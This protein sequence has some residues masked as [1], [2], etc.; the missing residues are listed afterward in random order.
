MSAYKKTGSY[1]LLAFILLL[2][3]IYFYHETIFY[4]P[5][6]IHAWT[7]S[8][9]LSIA[10]QFLENG[11]NLFKP[12]THNLATVEGVTGVDLPLNEFLV[13]IS[14]KIFNTEAPFIF[15]LYTL[16]LSVAGF[17]YLFRLSKLLNQHNV[18]CSIGVVVFVFTCPVITYY[19]AGLIPS[20]GSFAIMLMAYYYYFSFLKQSQ[21]KH[22][23]IS[24]VMLTLAALIRSP[25]NIYLFAVLLHQLLQA[26]QNRKIE[27]RQLFS[28]V[29]A[30]TILITYTY[31]K[32]WLNQTYGSQFLTALMPAQN[33]SDFFQTLNIVW[34]TW[35]FQLFTIYHYILLGLAII[36]I[37]FSFLKKTSIPALVKH[38]LI[39]SFILITGFVVYFILMSKQFLHHEYYFID[40]FYAAII[41]LLIAG[42]ALW[43][44]YFNSF[45]IKSFIILIVLIFSLSGATVQSKK[46][47]QLK[48]AETL[49]DR[50][51]VT[52][53]NFNDSAAFLDSLSI[54]KKAKMLVLD[55]YSTNAP[56]ILMKRKGYTILDT[57]AQKLEESLIFD[58]DYIVTQDVFFP[59][60]VVYN[61]P[62][63]LNKLKRIGGNGKI[64]I[65]TLLSLEK[66]ATLAQQLGIAQPTTV[67][68]INF[69]QPETNTLSHWKNVDKLSQ[70]NSYS[71]PNAININQEISFGATYKIKLAKIEHPFNKIL[72]EGYFNTKQKNTQAFVVAQTQINNNTDFYSSFP[73][74]LKV[75]DEWFKYQCLFTLPGPIDT[76]A[77]FQCYLWNPNKTAF[78]ADDLKVTL[79]NK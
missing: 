25:F 71:A 37:I 39:H 19:Q 8:D 48:Y 64:S 3:S 53:K 73:L 7:Q 30:Y 49:W 34:D 59:S 9:R 23:Y 28:F 61:Y 18:M 2:L 24:I 67:S 38:S 44:Q 36:G 6:H 69:D 29:L 4:F 12:Q 27:L 74:K 20:S 76:S 70:V 77:T 32:N 40:S 35:K 17:F 26:I 55:A 33:L 16:L 54:S 63:I 62:S 15:R 22:F 66:P 56:L 5:S 68:N 42:F 46:V 47:Q 41:L 79:Y 14:M 78:L 75:T 58:F 52:R 50:G 43:Q 45:K 51:E 13:A 10:L 65:Y 60:D 57:K 11:F 72:F 1:V 21:N 31:Y